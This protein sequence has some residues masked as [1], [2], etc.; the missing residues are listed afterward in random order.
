MRPHEGVSDR[1]T[2]L[3]LRASLLILWIIAALCAWCILNVQEFQIVD[4]IMGIVGSGIFLVLIYALYKVYLE[5]RVGVLLAFMP[6][7]TLPIIAY[8]YRTIF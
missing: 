1:D 4:H 6:A 5:N 8:L 3:F 7:P 2:K